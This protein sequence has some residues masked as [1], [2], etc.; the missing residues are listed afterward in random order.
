MPEDSIERQLSAADNAPVTVDGATH[1][2]DRGI[3]TRPEFVAALRQFIAAPRSV[4]EVK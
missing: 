2:G 3:L 1:W 4:A